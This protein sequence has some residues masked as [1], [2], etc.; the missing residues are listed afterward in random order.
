MTTCNNHKKDIRAP[1]GIR[2]RNSIKRAAANPRL[3][4][5]GHWNRWTVLY[6]TK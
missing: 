1:G 3:R 5:R 4:Q 2:T 6:D